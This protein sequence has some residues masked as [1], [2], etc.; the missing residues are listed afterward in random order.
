MHI[1][2][3][4]AQ[5]IIDC[6]IKPVYH[7]PRYRDRKCRVLLPIPK[8]TKLSYNTWALES[9][10]RLACPLTMRSSK[11]KHTS[12]DGGNHIEICRHF[13]KSE[14]TPK[15]SDQALRSEIGCYSGSKDRLQNVNCNFRKSGSC[16]IVMK[17][18]G[19]DLAV[20]NMPSSQM[21]CSY[22]LLSSIFITLL[23]AA[24]PRN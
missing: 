23:A 19:C 21:E 3:A 16:S 13:A 14:T 6:R 15:K 18:R 17:R 11:K 12:R 20:S 8:L 10:C 4:S 7:A 22:Q 9:G 24:H 2:G 1:V 5:G